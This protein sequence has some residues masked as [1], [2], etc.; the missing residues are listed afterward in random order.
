MY[1]HILL[2][3]EFGEQNRIVED[4]TKEIQEF[5]KAKLTIIHIV[6]PTPSIVD[7]GE[8][9]LPIEYYGAGENIEEYAKKQLQPS[10]DRL[11]VPQSNVIVV[12]G[13]PNRDILLYAEDNNVDLIVVGSH[14]RHGLQLLLG[15]TANAIL[16]KAK[17]DV[18]AVRLKSD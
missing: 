12:T 10:V 17:C 2:A 18:L 7:M 1:K 9:A 6:E 15:S 4:R 11:N 16:H 5:T 13:K 3:A 8:I 14:G